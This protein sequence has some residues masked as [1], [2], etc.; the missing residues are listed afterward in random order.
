MSQR[1]Q[2]ALYI[3]GTLL[4]WHTVAGATSLPVPLIPQQ[5]NEWCWAASGQMIMNYLGATAV[6]QCQQA[7]NELGRTD[8]C[9]SPTPSA[10]VKCGYTQFDK[11]N[12]NTTHYGGGALPFS[13]L[14]SEIDSIGSGGEGNPAAANSAST[15]A[16]S[17][18]PGNGRIHG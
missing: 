12:F 10:C 11:Y 5:T 8:C 15:R 3:A 2:L 4:A 14:K 18:V 17:G 6:N 13:M 16:R 9:M 1:N 7:N